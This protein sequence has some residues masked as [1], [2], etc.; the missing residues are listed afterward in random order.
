MADTI[1]SLRMEPGLVERV[2]RVQA[3]MQDDPDARGR[4]NGEVTFS[5]ALRECVMAGAGLLEN[6]YPVLDPYAL[7]DEELDP[8]DVP[9]PVTG[10]TRRQA[11]RMAMAAGIPVPAEGA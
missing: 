8:L 10:Y 1:K 3:G 2:E 11:R 6:R 4:C 9:D 7:D 5:E